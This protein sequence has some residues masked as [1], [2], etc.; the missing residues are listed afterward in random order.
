MIQVNILIC[1]KK[2]KLLISETNAFSFS[3]LLQFKFKMLERNDQ[4][5]LF[6]L[7]LNTFK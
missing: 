6:P 5:G 3:L 2:S 7:R 1:F 4:D